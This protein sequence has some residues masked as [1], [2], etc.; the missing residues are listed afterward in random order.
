[1]RASSVLK[2]WDR[3]L[4]AA[5]FPEI[6]ALPFGASPIFQRSARGQAAGASSSSGA[7]ERNR[8]DWPGRFPDKRL[9]SV[10]IP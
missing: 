8:L 2:N 1:M 10:A 9:T 6:R 4:K 3:H 5:V 7:A